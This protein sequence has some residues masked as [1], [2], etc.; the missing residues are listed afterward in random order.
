MNSL[1]PDEN[2]LSSQMGEMRDDTHD[3]SL[4]SGPA[5]TQMKEHLKWIE[6]SLLDVSTRLGTE[7]TSKAPPFPVLAK[8]GVYRLAL[9]QY[10]LNGL[11]WS[12]Y[13]D[14]AIVITGDSSFLERIQE[15]KKD[16]DK[17]LER[18]MR[19]VA[20]HSLRGDTIDAHTMQ[21]YIQKWREFC[22]QQNYSDCLSVF[23][24]EE[25]YHDS[26]QSLIAP[27]IFKLG[28]IMVAISEGVM[29]SSQYF[30]VAFGQAMRAVSILG[31]ETPKIIHFRALAFLITISGMFGLSDQMAFLYTIMRNIILRLNIHRKETYTRMKPRLATRVQ[32]LFWI[33]YTYSNSFHLLTDNYPPIACSEIT[34]PVPSW[35]PSSDLCAISYVFSLEKL[36]ERI[37]EMFLSNQLWSK[38]REEADL[39][40][41]ALDA[42]LDILFEELP[43]NVKI[44]FAP[45]RTGFIS[46]LVVQRICILKCVVSWQMAFTYMDKSAEEKC[47]NAALMILDIALKRSRTI[48]RYVSVQSLLADFAISVLTMCVVF[49]PRDQRSE[50]IITKVSTAIPE[51]RIFALPSTGRALESVWITAC[52]TMRK[53]IDTAQ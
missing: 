26:E 50:R 44:G 37:R 48:K 2:Y 34:I 18:Y 22:K 33:T 40:A 11:L 19:E 12:P 25:D 5:S 49:Y 1:K 45:G 41:T 39:E 4:A 27:E 9:G 8:R 32:S 51:L 30:G 24:N 43:E 23:L 47:I 17:A 14:R 13:I 31:F 15:N 3:S 6:R 52:E 28:T 42:E 29:P 35:P 16:Y 7:E 53:V 10:S 21:D 20:L 38:S 46:A 36:T